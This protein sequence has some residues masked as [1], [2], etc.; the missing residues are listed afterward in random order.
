MS[1]PD[2][3]YPLIWTGWL[4]FVV[5]SFGVIEGLAIHNHATTLS[6]FTW[7]VYEQW[8]LIAVVY[9]MIFGGL[10]VHFWWHWSPPG[11]E[12]KG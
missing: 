10:A 8:P 5:A 12:N 3:K 2:R 9:G 4:L 6:R 11:S 7:E 1:M